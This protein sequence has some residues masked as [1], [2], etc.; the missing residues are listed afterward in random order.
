[1]M[2]PSDKVIIENFVNL[3]IRYYLEYKWYISIIGLIVFI[4]FLWYTPR[5]CKLTEI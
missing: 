1:M 4:Y 2:L 3:I 5:K